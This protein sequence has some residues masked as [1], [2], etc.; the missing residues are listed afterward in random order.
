MIYRGRVLVALSGGVDSAVAAALLIEAG[1]QV[2]GVTFRLWAEQPPDISTS[3]PASSSISDAIKDACRIA[4]FLGI[5]HEVVDLR[6]PFETEVVDY[7]TCEYSRGRTPNPCVICNRKIKFAALLHKAKQIKSPYIATGHYARVEYCAERGRHLLKKGLDQAKDQSY[8]LYNLT[9]EQL[10]RCL[11]PLGGLTKKQVRARAR[12][13][14]L[15]VAG[16]KESQEICFIPGNDYRA[17]LKHRGIKVE[18]GPIVDR[19]GQI[20]GRHSG[21]PF[22]TVGQRRGLGLN[23]RHPLYVLEIRLRDN[24]IVVGERAGLYRSKAELAEINLIA[25]SE[26]AQEERVTVKIRYRAPE[27]PALLAPLSKGRQARLTFETPQPA[28]A[29]GQAAVFYRDDL[30][31]GGGLITAA[32]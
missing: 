28:V 2:T 24:T 29:P 32:E 31:L 13:L 18:P 23:A 27:V 22:Y 7:F 1:Y 4:E 21:V 26:L 19:N 15:A 17:F 12:E 8:M 10:A 16:Q 5:A 30:V 3:L 9:Q 11:F 25:L 20:L 14:G 6:K